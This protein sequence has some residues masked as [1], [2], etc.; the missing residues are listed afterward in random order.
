MV[1][2]WVWYKHFKGSTHTCLVTA[3]AQVRS[4]AWEVPHAMATA[5]KKIKSCDHRAAL[6]NAFIQQSWQCIHSNWTQTLGT[7]QHPT[8]SDPQHERGTRDGRVGCTGRPLYISRSRVWTSFSALE[9]FY[10]GK[11]CIW[12]CLWIGECRH[13]VETDGRGQTLL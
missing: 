11:R 5:K 2:L 10:A 13:H 12:V 3:T 7:Q 4:L 6:P 8:W 1:N 9:K